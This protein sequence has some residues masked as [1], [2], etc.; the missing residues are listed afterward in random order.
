[1]SYPDDIEPYNFF[2]QLFGGRGGRRGGFFGNSGRGW[3]FNDIFREFDEM[4]RSFT[5][6]FKNIEDRVPKNLIKEYNTPE[7]GKVREVG[8]IVYGY[9]MTIGSDGKPK[10]REF[11]NVKSSLNER[12]F[13]GEQQPSI[14]SEREPLVDVSATDKEVKVVVEIP[15]VRKE[16]IKI[17][18][19]EKIVEITTEDPERKYHKTIEVPVDIDID[20]AKSN[21]N[22]GILEIIFKKKD[23][24]KPKGRQINIE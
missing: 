16:N 15:G 23:Q 14:S 10:I 11:G 12:G 22:N 13:F 19:Y 2:K 20:S 18:T 8:P 4:N 1:M 24:E 17:N 6:Q 9:S 21:Y 7:G 3:N 5:E